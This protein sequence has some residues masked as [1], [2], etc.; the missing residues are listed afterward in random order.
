MEVSRI[1]FR[2]ET[3]AKMRKGLTTADIGRLRY[4]KLKDLEKS[5]QL[6]MIKTR[7]ELSMAVGYRE[8]DFLTKGS[9]WVNRMIKRNYISE[10]LL[11]FNDY[12]KAPEYEY[13]L[14][15][16]VPNFTGGRVKRKPMST[17]RRTR[18]QDKVADGYIPEAP[19]PQVYDEKQIA[20]ETTIVLPIKIEITRGD[21][22]IKIEMSDSEG[23]SK[24]IT[25]IMKGE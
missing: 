11:G 23:A 20:S 24:L 17:T 15:G 9:S 16:I 18:W 14:T 10:T 1:T 3:K 5:G 4:E 2:D 13:H 6:S 12:T 7:K 8:E 25:A 22:A 19:K 21:M